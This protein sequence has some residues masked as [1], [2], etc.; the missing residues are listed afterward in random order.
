MNKLFLLI[1]FTIIA[2]VVFATEFTDKQKAIIYNEAI[3]T[4]TTFQDLNNQLA[5]AVVDLD[6]T[7]KISQKIIEQFVN[8]KSLV[9]NDLDPQKRMSEFFELETYMT[10]LILWYPD[11]MK[12]TLDFKNIKAGNIMSHEND[13]YTVDLMTT[14]ANNGNYLNRQQNELKTELL[15]RL[16]FFKQGNA[17]MNFK[18]AGVRSTTSKGGNNSNSILA[19]VKSVAFSEKDMLLIKDQ[20]KSLINDYINFLN[21]LADPNETTEDKGYYRI[22]FMS[23]FKDSTLKLANDIEPKPEEQW[24]SVAD[25]QQKFVLSY[26]DGVKNLGVNLDSAEYGKVIPEGNEKFYI[27]GYIDKYFSGKYQSKIVY[28]DNSRYDFKISF[29]RDENTFKNFKLASIDKFGV[30][31]YESDNADENEELPSLSIEPISRTGFLYGLEFVFG[32]AQYKDLNLTKN[33]VLNW[34]VE[35]KSNYAIK[36]QG[37]WYYN[38]YIGIN[39]ALGYS[40]SSIQ[41]SLNGTY[42][43]T[44]L[45]Y[46]KKN[47]TPHIKIIDASIDSSLYFNYLDIPITLILHS[48]PS[49]EK[50]SVFAEIGLNT[51]ILLKSNYQITGQY[52]TSGYYEQYI[53]AM[54]Y[55]NDTAWG[56]INRPQIN[57]KQKNPVKSIN[58]SLVTAIGISYPLDYFTTVF[59]GMQYN[60][61]LNNISIS[62]TYTDYLGNILSDEK[63]KLSNFGFKFGMRYKF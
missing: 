57:T 44:T 8:R 32:K 22:S 20:S 58:I 29:E 13:I 24:I 50:W 40:H 52:Q 47:N 59:M 49:P 46:D 42:Q 34:A 19:E 37:S 33:E 62:D 28:R 30:N 36:L 51:G 41:T 60:K 38:G 10:N 18:I 26:P 11:G 63:R 2:S 39:G 54:Q 45:S 14:K 17:F 35:N 61:G 25:Y 15:Y 6:E 5:D 53:P 56:F 1:S 3:K 4:L 12:M 16:A 21:L 7:N 55:I 27:N 9:Y 43:N 48:D 23:L 31:L